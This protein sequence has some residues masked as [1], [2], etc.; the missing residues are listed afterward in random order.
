MVAGGG[1][2]YALSTLISQSAHVSPCWH[3]VPSSPAEVIED[4]AAVVAPHRRA[5]MLAG[6]VPTAVG[7]TMRAIEL[8]DF[9]TA[10][11]AAAIVG[12]TAPF[13]SM[14]AKTALHRWRS[15]P[16]RH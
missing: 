15:P 2:R 6:T 16:G 11:A 14:S 4:L 7:L 13:P 8:V 3:T 1:F 9:G 5:T 12:K 10:Q